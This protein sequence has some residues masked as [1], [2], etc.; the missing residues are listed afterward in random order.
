MSDRQ[1]KNKKKKT[2]L[3]VCRDGRQFWT[4]QA[5]FWQWVREGTVVKAGDGPLNGNFTRADE[6]TFVVLSKTV[7]NFARPVHLR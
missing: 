4:T 5:Q 2:A 7:L 6:E 1:N 3:V